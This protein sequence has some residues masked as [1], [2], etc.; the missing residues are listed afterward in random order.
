MEFDP[1]VDIPTNA[2]SHGARGELVESPDE[3]APGVEA[4]L[5]REGPDVLDVL[6]HD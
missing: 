1:P 6:V 3:I 2:A 4:A 5:A